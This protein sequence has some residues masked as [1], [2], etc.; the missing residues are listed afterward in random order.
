MR[1]H[2]IKPHLLLAL[3]HVQFRSDSIHQG[4]RFAPRVTIPSTNSLF[5]C[6]IVYQL[7]RRQTTLLRNTRDPTQTCDVYPLCSSVWSS[8]DKIDSEYDSTGGSS[9][10][11]SDRCLHA[12]R[13]PVFPSPYL[14]QS[15][16]PTRSRPRLARTLWQAIGHGTFIH[17]GD[18][19]ASDS[20]RACESGRRGAR[21]GSA[22]DDPE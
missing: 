18:T 6:L 1:A 17:G 4:H 8:P 9:A 15:T 19:A 14:A 5:S 20:T 10:L 22:E 12:V 7:H 11:L 16:F 21:L 13:M 3:H 2:H